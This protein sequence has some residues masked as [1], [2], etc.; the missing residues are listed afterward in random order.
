MIAMVKSLIDRVRGLSRQARVLVRRGEVDAELDEELA[1]H[2]EMEAREYE[3]A[4]MSAEEARRAALVS[5]NGVERTKELVREGRWVRVVEDVFTDARQ[6]VRSLT[7]T[8]TFSTI[9]VLTLALGIAAN[10]TMFGMMNALLFRAPPGVTADGRVTVE[11]YSREF[12]YANYADLRD[13]TSSVIDLAAY[14]STEIGIGIP[15]ELP[16]PAT[17]QMVSPN[18][19]AVLGVTMQAGRGFVADDDYAGTRSMVVVISDGLW[20]SMFGADPGAAGRTI[21]V[22]GHPFTV[23]GIAPP[24]FIGT[25]IE[26]ATNVWTPARAQPLVMPR[27]YDVLGGRG[28][29]D[30]TVF[31]RLVTPNGETAQVAQ[32]LS[33]AY[34]NIMIAND[35]PTIRKGT[36]RARV[37]VT[38]IRG[39]LPASVL[40]SKGAASVMAAAFTV[41]GLVLLIVCANIGNL[42]LSRSAARQREFGVRAALGARRFRLIRMFTTEAMVLAFAAGFLS[43]S[44]S[45]V[46]ARQ[47]QQ[48]FTA[49]MAPLHITIDAR[50]LGFAACMA[51]L[52]A[53]LFGLVPALRFSRPDVMGVIKGGD[54]RLHGTRAQK[55]FVVTQ[56][57]LSVVLLVTAALLLQHFRD[58]QRRDVG[59]DPSHL[60]VG[61]FDVNTRGLDTTRT[62][63]LFERM[64]A[65]LARVPGVRAVSAPTFAPFTTGAMLIGVALPER[66]GSDADASRALGL[67]V[68]AGYFEALELP[69]LAGRYLNATDDRSRDTVAVVSESFAREMWGNA[70]PVGRIFLMRRDSSKVRVVG[71]VADARVS[72]LD[73]DPLPQVYT[74]YSQTLHLAEANVLMRTSADPALLI[75]AVRQAMRSVDS[76]LALFG[77]DPMPRLIARKMAY[78]AGIAKIVSA[79]G[80]LALVLAAIG[81]YG[82]VAFSVVGRTREIGVR[83]ALGAQSGRVVAGF[84]TEALKLSLIGI[85]IGGFLAYGFSKLVAAMVEGVRTD[86]PVPMVTVAI[87]LLI[88]TVAA[89]AIPAF[90]AGG[91]DPMQSLRTE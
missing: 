70:D 14:R 69:L 61:S 18:Y 31:G 36:D 79:F 63:E 86:D 44:I 43:I 67:G 42:L 26:G 33:A 20:R 30:F 62:A 66:L 64:R 89:S 48:L 27:G 10:G 2:V 74:P 50:T 71:V 23:V 73:S 11:S 13:Q 19:F 24:G 40:G 88:T 51:F 39:W 78:T 12:T 68:T 15:G 85:V 72:D 6:A 56:V 38:P 53:L 17:A 28:F 21:R 29:G 16:V 75:P 55:F 3:R 57:A 46:A 41:T 49:D 47:F 35:I 34:R 45:L 60:L 1:F 65:T 8:P 82:L 5:F 32:V 37:I 84:I 58:A 90:R 9:A 7:R 83:M 59:F 91:I 25:D 77:L 22:N 54:S 87:C 80:V 52:S 81:L 76:D 4:G